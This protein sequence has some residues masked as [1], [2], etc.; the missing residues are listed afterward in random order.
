MPDW[1]KLEPEYK[2]LWNPTKWKSKEGPIESDQLKISMDILLTH[3]RST[4][5]RL[6]P[7]SRPTPTKRWKKENNMPLKPSDQLERLMFGKEM[8]APII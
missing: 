3:T 1:A 8:T 6:S 7:V 4:L 5:E 2:R